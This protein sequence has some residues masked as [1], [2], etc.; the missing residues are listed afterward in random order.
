MKPSRLVAIDHILIQAALGK[1]DV[2][3]WFYLDV[4]KLEEV[5][6]GHGQ[7]VFRSARLELRVQLVEETKVDPVR[8]RFTVNVPSLNEAMELLSEREV[9][10][11]RLSGFTYTDR[12]IGTNDPAGNRVE[13]KQEWPEAPL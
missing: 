11:V 10:F 4:C 12:R 3:R 2:I 8:R 9:S 6:N 7:L 5:A 13:L 1:E